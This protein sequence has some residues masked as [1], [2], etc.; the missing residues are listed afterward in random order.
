MILILDLV[1]K[2]V[3]NSL[4]WLRNC[5]MVVF[6]SFHTGSF[7]TNELS[8]NIDHSRFLYFDTPKDHNFIFIL[9]S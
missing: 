4:R 5:H 2:V 6:G 3:S 9:Y 8:P 1:F 7:Q